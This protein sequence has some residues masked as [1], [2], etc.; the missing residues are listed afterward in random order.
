MQGKNRF[1]YIYIKKSS[2]LFDEKFLSNFEIYVQ[3]FFSFLLIMIRECIRI[4]I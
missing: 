3:T 1:F 2:K 4:I